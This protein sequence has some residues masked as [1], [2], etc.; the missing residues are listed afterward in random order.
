MISTRGPQSLGGRIGKK[1]IGIHYKF[2]GFL[3]KSKR[4]RQ[5]SAF[6]V[7]KR[8]QPGDRLTVQVTCE[9]LIAL[10]PALPR[11]AED[12]VEL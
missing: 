8:R 7:H 11:L 4:T 5:K 1:D 2:Q 10:P 3:P 6:K 9:M 12:F